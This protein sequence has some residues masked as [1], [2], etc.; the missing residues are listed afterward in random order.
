M[1]LT[2][3]EWGPSVCLR[4]PDV[5]PLGWSADETGA[6]VTRDGGA[7][8]GR[9]GTGNRLCLS[10]CNRFRLISCLFFLSGPWFVKFLPALQRGGRR[11]RR[12]IAGRLKAALGYRKGG[13]QQSCCRFPSWPLGPGSEMAF[14]PEYF[15]NLSTGPFRAVWGAAGTLRP[16]RRAPPSFRRGTTSQHRP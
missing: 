15:P 1:A 10:L 3:S 13:P 6:V 2:S 11:R 7:A 4:H 9:D 14:F 8:Q 12:R 5:G 16:G